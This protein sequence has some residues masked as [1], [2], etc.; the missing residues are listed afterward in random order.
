M[1]RAAA[2]GAKRTPE[3]ERPS[4]VILILLIFSFFSFP[5]RFTIEQQIDTTLLPRGTRT[6]SFSISFQPS[7]YA[8][9]FSILS[10]HRQVRQHRG[11]RYYTKP[12][13]STLVYKT[14]LLLV[15]AGIASHRS[16]ITVSNLVV[17]SPS[18]ACILLSTPS[19]DT[20][21]RGDLLSMAPL[22]H[23][24]YT[25]T[26]SFSFLGRHFTLA[27]T[28]LIHRSCRT[29]ALPADMTAVGSSSP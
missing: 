14:A 9:N 16:T 6:L 15:E 27:A 19:L 5:C 8:Y 25:H 13:H 20:R 11:R 24:T 23:N 2:L 7:L 28:M 18:F 3:P 22:S 29:F 12:R 17:F 26:P 21:V 4:H 10:H 1:R